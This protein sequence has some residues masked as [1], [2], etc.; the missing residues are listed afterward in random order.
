MDEEEEHFHTGSLVWLPEPLKFEALLEAVSHETT[1]GCL[2]YQYAI[3]SPSVLAS[4]FF[5][6]LPFSDLE[7]G[8]GG[9]SDTS[10]RSKVS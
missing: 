8:L 2:S 9:Q 4:S 7:A 1:I 10:L 6:I 3:K 5:F